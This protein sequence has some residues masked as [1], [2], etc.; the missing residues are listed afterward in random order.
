MWDTGNTDKLYDDL[1]ILQMP[2]L[3]KHN[4]QPQQQESQEPGYQH[5]L[6]LTLE[7]ALPAPHLGTKLDDTKVCIT[8]G[9]HLGA[10]IVER[11]SVVLCP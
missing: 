10:N 6:P 8:T 7:L 2:P 5:Y 3:C 4:F 11:H 9:L 1:L